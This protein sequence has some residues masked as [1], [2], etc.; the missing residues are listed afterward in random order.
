MLIVQGMQKRR[1]RTGM[2]SKFSGGAISWISQKQEVYYYA[3]QRQ[4]I[5]VSECVK[6]LMWLKHLLN[7]ITTLETSFLLVDNASAVKLARNPEFYKRSKYVNVRYQ[8]V[9]EKFIKSEVYIKHVLG[10]MQLAD[11]TKLLNCLRFKELCL[12]LGLG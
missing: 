4:S 8:F 5:A 3:Q 6:E 11:T 7:D 10:K 1:S 9:R 2:T 12:L